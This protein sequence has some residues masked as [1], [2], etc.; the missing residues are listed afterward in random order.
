MA[1]PE[2]H[3]VSIFCNT[4]DVLIGLNCAELHCALEEVKGNSGEPIARLTP[5]EFSGINCSRHIRFWQIWWWWQEQLATGFWQ[6]VKPGNDYL[7][8]NLIKT[9]LNP[10]R[11]NDHKCGWLPQKGNRAVKTWKFLYRFI[12]S[13]FIKLPLTWKCFYRNLLMEDTTICNEINE[14]ANLNYD[15]NT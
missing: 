1:T 6:P 11:T 2:D 9:A 8:H 5:L 15:N 4:T 14:K 12:T 3:R 7:S 13:H 10:D